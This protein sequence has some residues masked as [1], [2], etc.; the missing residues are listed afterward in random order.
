MSDKKRYPREAALTVAAELCRGLK[1]VTEQLIVAGSLRRMKEMVGDV[2]IVFTPR[3]E[4]RRADLLNEENVNLA[5]EAI[6]SMLDRGVI[7]KRPGKT[8]HTSW[9]PKNK[10]AVHVAS[11]IPVDLFATTPDCWHNYLVCRTGPGE[12]NVAI[13]MAAQKMGWT[14]NPY[15][16]G[17]SRGQ[18][19]MPMHSEQEVF[20]FV[21][22]PYR[23][24]KDRV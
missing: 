6:Q 9:G 10:L 12:S 7:T 18:E 13:C 14:W 21:N 4:T 8:G 23:Q 16:S 17:F 19:F 22:L 5:E 3:F 24:P 1:P 11:G 20:T 2:E 15:G